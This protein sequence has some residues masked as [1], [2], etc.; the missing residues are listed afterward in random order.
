M[1]VEVR[2]RFIAHGSARRKGGMETERM[3]GQVT[4]EKHDAIDADDEGRRCVGFIEGLPVVT[5]RQEGRLGRRQRMIPFV[6]LRIQL[7][8]EAAVRID[9]RKRGKTEDDGTGF[10]ERRRLHSEET[11]F[12]T[13]GIP[14]SL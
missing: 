9:Q 11:S 3:D 13:Y 12:A 6:F 4:L 7:E 1:S 2:R 8:L 5:R 14:P 10:H